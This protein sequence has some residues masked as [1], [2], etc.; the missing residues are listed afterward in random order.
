MAEARGTVGRGYRYLFIQTGYAKRTCA[1]RR[2]TSLYVQ[3]DLSVLI[4][5]RHPGGLLGKDGTDNQK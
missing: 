2:V 3:Q 5:F 1:F 4:A